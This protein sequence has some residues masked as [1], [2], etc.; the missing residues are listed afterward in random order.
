MP[1]GNKVKHILLVEDNDRFQ[2]WYKNEFSTLES[3]HSFKISVTDVDSFQEV[4]ELVQRVKSSKGS[5]KVDCAVVDI[6]IWQHKPTERTLD[7][8]VSIHW[9]IQAFREIQTI[10]ELGK[11]LIITA[12]KD[13]VLPY[14]SEAEK[15]RVTTK[16]IHQELFQ[17]K[18]VRCLTWKAP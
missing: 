7:E 17:E 6:Q 3:K 16:D 4:E 9:G 18:V 1:S 10:L 8:G 2:Q 5:E 12:Y 13:N 14:L 11:I 15:K